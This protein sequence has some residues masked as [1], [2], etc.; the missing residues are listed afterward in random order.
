M[1]SK[2]SIPER[3]V[4]ARWWLFAAC[5]LLVFIVSYMVAAN[6]AHSFWP[7]TRKVFFLALYTCTGP[8][9]SSVAGWL[10][11]NEPVNWVFG[12]PILFLLLLHPLK[13]RTLTAILTL[14]GFMIWLFMGIVMVY[15]KV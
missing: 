8:F 14:L 2:E 6:Y 1:K 11:I 5:S 15:V 13:P 12:I 3:I 7:P 4:N 10:P 9:A